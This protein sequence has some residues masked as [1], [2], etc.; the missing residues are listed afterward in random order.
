MFDHYKYGGPPS[1][2]ELCTSFSARTKEDEL[3]TARGRQ[4]RGSYRILSCDNMK[5]AAL[6]FRWP[7]FCVPISLLQIKA[8]CFLAMGL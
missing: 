7:F 3:R 4:R 2:A 6:K 1:H 5:D 8:T